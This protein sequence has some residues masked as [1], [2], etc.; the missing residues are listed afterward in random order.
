[1]WWERQ[2]SGS[3]FP[4]VTSTVVSRPWKKPATAGC[5]DGDPN[6]PWLFKA[7][8]KWTECRP[9][10]RTKDLEGFFHGQ[11]EKRMKKWGL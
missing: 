10:S 11:L 3:A 4:G 1:M 9:H 6:K 8:P 2:Q 7:L 5:G